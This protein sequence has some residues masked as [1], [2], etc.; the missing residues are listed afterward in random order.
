M[1]FNSR[2]ETV[3]LLLAALQ[4][5]IEAVKA[6]ATSASAAAAPASAAAAAPA[7]KL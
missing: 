2:R 6:G 4:Q 7:A 3:T 1:G 5:S